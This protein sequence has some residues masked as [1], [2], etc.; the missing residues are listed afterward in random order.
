MKEIRSGSAS[1]GLVGD[2]IKFDSWE[3]CDQDLSLARRFATH[4]FRNIAKCEV[5][6][7]GGFV[8]ECSQL[9]LIGR[10]N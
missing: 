4:V 6:R 5:D 3:V 9:R 2:V 1:G 7:I 10:D 8:A